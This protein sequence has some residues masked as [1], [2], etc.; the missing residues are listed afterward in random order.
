MRPV[1]HVEGLWSLL[2]IIVVC[3]CRSCCPFF[4]FLWRSTCC[5]LTRS[6]LHF[7]MTHSFRSCCPLESYLFCCFSSLFMFIPDPDLQ[8]W[9]DKDFKYFYPQKV[10]LSSRKYDPR[11]LSR[12]RIFLF[13]SIPDPGPGSRGQKSTDNWNGSATQVVIFSNT[14]NFLNRM[15]LFFEYCTN[16]A[17][18]VDIRK[19]WL[20]TQCWRK[21]TR[22]GSS[23]RR[24][25]RLTGSTCAASHRSYLSGF[26]R[27]DNHWALK[28]LTEK[29]LF[30]MLI[31]AE[32]CFW[33]A[34]I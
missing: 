12:I 31:K 22:S 1:L 13:F 14:P 21:W 25:S 2:G 8:H 4:I 16:S 33:S 15:W 30:F 27:N 19:H 11:C 6:A 17:R 3:H 5:E 24:C 28:S 26:L 23:T 10:L 29:C 32:T 18:F 7:T 9:I 34:I 20:I